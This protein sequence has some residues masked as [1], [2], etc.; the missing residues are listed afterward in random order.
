MQQTPIATFTILLYPHSM[1]KTI[2]N[3]ATT[4]ICSLHAFLVCSFE[5]LHYILA[6]LMGCQDALA[7]HTT[8][9]TSVANGV[10]LPLQRPSMQ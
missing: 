2:D 4:D 5:A 3:T 9:L 7:S 1:K 10:L 6:V 8:I